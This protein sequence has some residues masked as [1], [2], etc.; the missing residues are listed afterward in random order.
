MSFT[1]AND[2]GFSESPD[3][4][5]PGAKLFRRAYPKSSRR[6]GP[7]IQLVL[8]A[9]HDLLAASLNEGPAK[10]V[11]NGRENAFYHWEAN[12][13]AYCPVEPV[14]RLLAL[15]RAIVRRGADGM[16]RSDKLVWFTV[17][18]E[19]QISRV[20]DAARVLLSVDHTFFHGEGGQRRFVDGKFIEPNAIESHQ[21]FAEQ[22][23]QPDDAA[24]LTVPEAWE[25]YWKFCSVHQL[26][27]LRRTTFRERFRGEAITRFGIGLRHD[28]KIGEKTAQ[29][30]RGL[31]LDGLEKNHTPSSPRVP[32]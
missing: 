18:D 20:V 30:W 11:Y 28:L 9:N 21:L 31:R 23:V 3:D 1:S 17:W 4:D 26:P 8:G 16:I 32:Q 14:E 22:A 24:V 7:P 15:I 25:G 5:L 19:K 6:F 2:I 10:I 12:R 29:G 13:H 27:P